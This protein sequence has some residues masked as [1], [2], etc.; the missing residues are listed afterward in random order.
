MSKRKR[1]DCAGLQIMPVNPDSPIPLYYQVE[2]DLRRLIKS[3]KLPPG[4]TLPPEME[5]CQVY[6]VGRHTVRKAMARLNADDLIVRQAGRGTFVKQPPDRKEFLLDRS[7]TRQMAEMGKHAHSNVLEISEGVIQD[8]AP[9]LLRKYLGA[10][11]LHLARLRFGD[12]VPIG[13]QYTTVIT[14]LCPGLGSHDFNHD[15]LYDVLSRAYGLVIAT[16]SH[17]VS[18]VAADTYQARL[19]QVA[20]G[21]PLLLVKTTAFLDNQQIIEHT[22]SYY[23]ADCYEYSITQNYTDWPG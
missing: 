14:E 17:T 18:A 8:D 11:Y 2:T 23:R 6:Q 9:R 19:L 7:F 5:L 20:E 4:A 10:H 15:S 3:G 12:Q 13:L 1:V 22:T 16:I 21:T